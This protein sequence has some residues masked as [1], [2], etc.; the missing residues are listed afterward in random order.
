MEELQRGGHP[1]VA[2]ILRRVEDGGPPGSD[3]DG[4][5]RASK[6]ADHMGPTCKRLNQ[7]KGDGLRGAR[8]GPAR[9]EIA[10]PVVRNWP[11]RVVILLSLSFSDFFLKF[12]LQFKF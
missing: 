10:G 7:R 1:S 5:T 8:T 4:V 2:G 3:S 9:R 11:A 12:E 6:G